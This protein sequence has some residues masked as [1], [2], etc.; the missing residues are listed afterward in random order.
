MAVFLK[1]V[2]AFEAKRRGVL[3]KRLGARNMIH[4]LQ[5]IHPINYISQYFLRNRLLYLSIFRNIP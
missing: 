1:N 5:T 2:G 4:H 3:K